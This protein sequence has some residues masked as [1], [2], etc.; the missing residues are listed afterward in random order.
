MTQRI[1]WS[2]IRA[3]M[4]DLT[5]RGLHY[6]PEIVTAFFMGEGL[7]KPAF[8]HV[9]IPGRKFRLDVSWPAISS[10]CWK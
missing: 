3:G 9:H 7:P 8:E 5:K 2:K 10:G 4:K 1:E 6:K